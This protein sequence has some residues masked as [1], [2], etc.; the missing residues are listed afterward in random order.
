MEFTCLIMAARRKNTGRVPSY[1]CKITKH[2]S[3]SVLV[4]KFDQVTVKK[5]VLKVLEIWFSAF[6]CSALS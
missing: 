3:L 5:E 6:Q 1:D 2:R 4:H